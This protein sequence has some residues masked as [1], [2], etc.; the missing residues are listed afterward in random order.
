MPATTV[1][2]RRRERQKSR[3]ALTFSFTSRA[4]VHPA[5]SKRNC[6]PVLPAQSEEL[7]ARSVQIPRLSATTRWISRRS[8]PQQA[9]AAVEG[10]P[11]RLLM[12]PGSTQRVDERCG[13]VAAV[14]GQFV[15][16]PTSQ[17]I[18]PRKPALLCKIEIRDIPDPSSHPS[19]TRID[20]VLYFLSRFQSTSPPRRLQ[21]QSRR[22]LPPLPLLN[23]GP[24]G[25]ARVGYMGRPLG[26]EGGDI[27]IHARRGASST[28]GARRRDLG[29]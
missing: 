22:Q 24:G 23:A 28:P 2:V 13:D 14:C 17:G 4:S 3:R 20:D 16:S 7:L 10:G 19:R 18:S 1:P 11:S 12:K 25:N 8:H 29:A 6:P 26:G 27:V 5:S 9:R 15:H 21:G